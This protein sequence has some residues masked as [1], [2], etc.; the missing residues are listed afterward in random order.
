MYTK[1][2]IAR[3]SIETKNFT[4]RGDFHSPISH[5]HEMLQVPVGIRR[6]ETVLTRHLNF[7]HRFS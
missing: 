7:A 5:A 3:I 6:V 2:M 4:P 1:H